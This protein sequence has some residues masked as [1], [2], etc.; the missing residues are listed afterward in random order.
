VA[1]TV[2]HRDGAEFPSYYIRQRS[3]RRAGSLHSDMVSDAERI[4]TQV[5]NRTEPGDAGGPM[6]CY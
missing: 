2:L 6:F 5:T 4:E 1:S 3:A